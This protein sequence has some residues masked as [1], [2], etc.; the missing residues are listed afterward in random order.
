M[1]VRDIMSPDVSFVTASA[2]VTEIAKIMR[3]K[4]IGAVPVVQ[5]ENV[6]G[7]I[8]DR[9]IVLRVLAENKDMN[10]ITSEQIMTADP[11]CIDES[12][13]IDSAAEM[14]AEYQVKR[15]PVLSN[16]KLV[17][18]LALGDMAIEQIHMDEAG[19]A[20]SGISRGINH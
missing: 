17:G 13:D 12:K 7:I 4:D 8:T 16:G 1:K 19:D 6:V 3:D 11:V 5:N 15:L 10:Q 14:M 20:L 18:M 2:K 9:D